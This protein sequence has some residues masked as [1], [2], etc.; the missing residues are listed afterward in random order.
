MS[1]MGMFRQLTAWTHQKPR[2][3]SV[4]QLSEFSLLVVWQG[5]SILGV[6]ALVRHADPL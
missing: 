3:A 5:R 6:P 2:R 1:D 4:A